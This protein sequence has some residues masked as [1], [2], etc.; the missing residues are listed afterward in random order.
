MNRRVTLSHLLTVP[1]HLQMLMGGVKVSLSPLFELLIGTFTA[2]CSSLTYYNICLPLVAR[3]P[4]CV[5]QSREGFTNRN[6]NYTLNN[7][8]K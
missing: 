5:R 7:K 8:L 1:S 6:Y 3:L 4:Q 2:L